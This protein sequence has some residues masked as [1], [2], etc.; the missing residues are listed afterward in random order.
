MY[1][2]SSYSGESFLSIQYLI[3]VIDGAV[4]LYDL[5]GKIE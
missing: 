5:M 4:I 1:C 2:T 3:T